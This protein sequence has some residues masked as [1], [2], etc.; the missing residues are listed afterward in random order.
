MK[1]PVLFVSSLLCTVLVQQVLAVETIPLS[2]LKGGNGFTIQ[3]VASGD[4]LGISGTTIVPHF[5]ASP[6]SASRFLPR[7]P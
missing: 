4:L 1:P 3:G 5:S 2:T 6:A 7:A